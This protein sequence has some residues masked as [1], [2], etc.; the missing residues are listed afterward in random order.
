AT[1]WLNGLGVTAFLLKY[2][3]APHGHPAP[4][5]D[6]LRAVRLVRS[7]AREFGVNPDRIGVMGASAGGHLAAA[8]A[9]LFDAPE[10]KTGASLD[11]TSASPDFIA[12]LYPVITMNGPFAHADST[13]NLLGAA[14]TT[15]MRDRLSVETQVLAK[16]P[17]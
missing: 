9:T 15:A 12:L 1:R 16:S 7:R 5:Q 11:A 14:P 17:P 6:V 2:R 13:R 8:A 3:V 4:L 10:G